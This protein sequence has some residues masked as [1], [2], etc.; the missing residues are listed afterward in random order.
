MLH[1]SWICFGANAKIVA[2]RKKAERFEPDDSMP[3]H[4]I[5]SEVELRELIIR[6][7][8]NVLG[9]D[10]AQFF[11]LWL[12]PILL[13]LRNTS[14][15]EIY[16]AGLDLDAWAKP[17]GPMPEILAYSDD[18]QK[19]TANCF[20]CGQDAR[21]TQKIGGSS[22]EQIQ[23]GAENIYEARCENCWTSPA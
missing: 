17:F 6:E 10:E 15:L 23:V 12:G 13:E 7:E 16:I 21:F 5:Q 20:K 22:S 11:G 4:P 3:A 19:F 1:L 18:A 9:I 8:P 14:G 2:K